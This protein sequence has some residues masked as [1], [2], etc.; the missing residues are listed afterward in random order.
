METASFDGAPRPGGPAPSAEDVVEGA[1]YSSRSPEAILEG[2]K[3]NRRSRDYDPAQ[4]LGWMSVALGAAALLAPGPL[5]RLI[6]MPQHSGLL[7]LVGLRELAS[8]AGL[9]T[10]K[11]PTPWLWSRVVGDAMDLGLIGTAL[12]PTNPGRDR[13]MGALAAVAAITAVDIAAS[14][15]ETSRRREGIPARARGAASEPVVEHTVAVNRSPQECYEFWRDVSNLPK[16]S[17]MLESVTKLDDKRSHWVLRGP[18]G[19]R[20]E[21]DSEISADR[22]GER[23]AWHSLPG[24]D[25][26]HSGVVN[27]SRAP[28]D[29]G[30]YV[31]VTMHYR[32]PGGRLARGLAKLLGKD[33]NHE[34]REDLRRF[35]S[36]IETGEVPSTRGQPSGRRSMLG[37]MTRDGR[38]SREGAK[39]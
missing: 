22:P 38:E 39:S 12:R 10:Q 1:S 14:L 2:S 11:E 37:R 27:F 36:A 29:R 19:T 16:F 34:V 24:S 7:R 18:R 4:A 3:S 5:G 26:Q 23:L 20:I 28:G 33:P 32:P 35:K 6:G 21:W 15:R 8:A 31:S 17:T 25:V 30:T 13:A 9:L